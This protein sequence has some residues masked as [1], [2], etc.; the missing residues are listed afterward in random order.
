MFFSSIT[1]NVWIS[2]TFSIFFS[3]R[4]QCKYCNENLYTFCV[5]LSTAIICR[6][7]SSLSPFYRQYACIVIL[8]LFPLVVR[9]YKVVT[10]HKRHRLYPRLLKSTAQS[11]F[12]F[13]RKG[14]LWSPIGSCLPMQY[15]LQ[16]NRLNYY[17]KC[18][19]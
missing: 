11:C 18:W 5:C 1:Q 4:V 6:P 19:N 17:C 7:D 14:L 8:H 10:K 9:M 15:S 2:I 12:E 13:N 16:G 3:F